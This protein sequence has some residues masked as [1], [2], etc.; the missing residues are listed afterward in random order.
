MD[1]CCSN[2]EV[3]KKF[4]ERWPRTRVERIVPDSMEHKEFISDCLAHLLYHEAKPLVEDT[5]A[6]H[7]RRQKLWRQE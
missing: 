3:C 1:N 5:L 7:E 2:S 6:T 4:L